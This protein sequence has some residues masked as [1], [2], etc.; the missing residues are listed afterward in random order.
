MAGVICSRGGGGGCSGE[1][2]VFIVAELG[3]GREEWMNGALMG[4]YREFRWGIVE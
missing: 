4:G 2:G 1:E 3:L